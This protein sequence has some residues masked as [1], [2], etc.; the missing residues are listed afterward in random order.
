MTT[1]KTTEKKPA[2]TKKPAVK[3][4]EKPKTWFESMQEK[5]K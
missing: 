4:E 2:A 1:K 3:K 5:I